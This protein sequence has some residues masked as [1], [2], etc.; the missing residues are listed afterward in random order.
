MIVAAPFLVILT[1]G[2][3]I[4]IVLQKLQMAYICRTKVPNDPNMDT[5]TPT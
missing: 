5:N 3:I 1:I 4:Q 2:V